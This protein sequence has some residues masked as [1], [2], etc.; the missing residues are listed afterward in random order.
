MSLKTSSRPRRA[1]VTGTILGFL[2]WILYWSLPA[3]WGPAGGLV[4]AAIIFGRQLLQKKPKIMDGFSLSFFALAALMLHGLHSPW[5]ARWEGVLVFATLALMALASLAARSPFTLQ[6]AREDWPREYWREPLFIQTNVHITLAW[7][8]AF[9]YGAGMTALNTLVPGF[10]PTPLLTHLGTITALVFTIFWPQ[11][12]PCRAVDRRLKEREARRP[13]WQNPD[14]AAWQQTRLFVPYNRPEK[15]GSAG[16][17]GAEGAA[18]HSP[19]DGPGDGGQPP[20]TWESDITPGGTG[21]ERPPIA[22]PASP[23]P[24]P[25][26]R[27]TPPADRFD[28]IVIGAGIG[29]LTAAARLADRGLRVCVLE[30]H[31]QPGGYCT[32]FVRKGYTFDG[33]VESVS[34][35]WP[36]GPVRLLLEE[37]GLERRIRFRRHGHRLITPGGVLDIP[38]NYVEF[39]NML[40]DLAPHEEEGIRTLM[41]ELQAAYYQVYQDTPRT[42]KVPAPPATVEETLSYP[43]D[44]PDFYRAMFYSWGEFLRRRV[45]DEHV[46]GILNMLTAYLGDRGPDTPAARMIPL[47]GYYVDGG[48]YPVGGSQRLADVLMEAVQER[49]GEVRLSTTVQRVLL[50]EGRVAGVSLGDGTCLLAP[51]VISNADPKQTFFRLVGAEH[52]PPDFV[53]RVERLRPSPSAFV[54]YLAL[55]RPAGLPERVFVRREGPLPRDT[56][57]IGGFLLV[58]N[59]PLDPELV[60]PGCGDL[61]MITLTRLEADHLNRMTPSGYRAF[62]EELTCTM[63]DY[64]EEV[65]PGIREHVVHVEAATP[66]TFYRYTWNHQGAIYGLEPEDGPEGPVWL[67]RKTPIPGLWLVGASVEPGPG[68][69]G[70]VI[71]GTYCANEIRAGRTGFTL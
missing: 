38:G 55:E 2:P 48:V 33:G 42:G 53:K 24:I 17:A 23:L 62:K 51:V 25:L 64:V 50:H 32:S 44:H 29:G 22:G 46:L 3:P 65:V 5:F 31:H 37:L 8:L 40:V 68:I 67:D 69:E 6:Y 7:A 14:F 56:F 59:S 10:P 60:P 1:G 52:L 9:I 49:E 12:Y 4:G 19:G 36:N 34:G 66:R 16:W 21:E 28:V 11:Y 35:C 13:P 20:V 54:L 57:G 45:Q 26:I 58:S 27:R 39:T 71:S 43:L 18:G 70:V 30:R 47:M 61:T 63:L 15:Y 41:G